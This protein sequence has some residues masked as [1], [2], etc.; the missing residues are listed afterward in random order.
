MKT[1]RVQDLYQYSLIISLL[2]AG[3]VSF[4]AE[5]TPINLEP[6]ALNSI[7]IRE[8]AA[9]YPD[10]NGYGIRIAAIGRSMTYKDG[11]PQGDFR[12]NMQHQALFGANVLFEDN[13]DGLTGIS[14]H[15]TAIT[16]LLV[17]NDAYGYHP[18]LGNFVYLGACPDA[19]VTSY[20]FWRFTS[21]Y[22]FAAHPFETDI[23]TMSLGE[24]FPAWW[25]R[26]IEN[27]VEEKGVVVFAAAGNGQN[28]YDPVLY[29]AAG[30]NVIAVG[31]VNAAVESNDE[32]SLSV[33]ASP[34]PACSSAG[35]TADLRCKPDLVAPGRG[36][37]VSASS[38]S[39]Y[40]IEGDWSSLATPITAGA[41][42]LLLQKAKSVPAL[43][44][45]V[46]S[47]DTNTMV[48]AI[49]LTSAQKL[50][51]WHKGNPTPEDDMLAPLDF[52][53][54]AGMLDAVKAHDVLTAGS[55]KPGQVQ[56]SGWHQAIL[57]PNNLI[58]SYDLTIS[59]PDTT[60]IT[61]TLCWNRVYQNQYPF[62]PVY[63]KDTDLRLELWGI[64]PQD[65]NLNQLLDISDSVNDNVE[66]IY[67]AAD[68]MFKSYRLIVRYSANAFNDQSYAIAWQ[69]GPDSTARNPF[70]YDLNNDARIN[71]T[72]RLV[73]FILD[74]NRADILESMAVVPEF[75][76]SPDRLQTLQLFWNR[77]RSFLNNW[78]S[79]SVLSGE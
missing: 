10:L 66:H 67:R 71:T 15:E 53:Q 75:N 4:A 1:L 28:A 74:Q 65:S 12:C 46:F 8:L 5:S 78:S 52:S 37:M 31:V 16:G 56:T 57:N 48:K 34:Q 23:V 35:P 70:W 72:D 69:T 29:P 41:T 77:W 79:T 55:Q 54:G 63:E 76:I 25:T 68:A 58:H 22:L 39:E 51:Y 20:E 17:G 33:F 47:G 73:Y 44:D 61:A 60:V 7:G 30:A 19:S 11:L 38:S 43:A 40:T 59:D 50:P 64:H 18:Q 21:L 24:I 13:S 45:A 42:A 36:L 26:G 3:A 49:L 62:E 14:A 27:L 2:L 6:A 32:K 9:S